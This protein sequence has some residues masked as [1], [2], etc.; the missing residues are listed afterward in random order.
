MGELTGEN[1]LNTISIHCLTETYRMSINP[2]GKNYPVN[3]TYGLNEDWH[4]AIEVTEKYD[5][6]RGLFLLVDTLLLHKKVSTLGSVL[7]VIST[8]VVNQLLGTWAL[9]NQAASQLYK[10][11]SVVQHNQHLFDVYIPLTDQEAA[12]RQ[13][14][15]ELQTHY[16][17]A[18]L[19]ERVPPGGNAER[20]WYESMR[21]WLLVHAMQRSAHGNCQDAFLRSAADHIRLAA[22]A[23]GDRLQIIQALRGPADEFDSLNNQILFKEGRIP[24]KKEL[25]PTAY[26]FL[27]TLVKVARG[28]HKSDQGQGSFTL[29]H[30]EL[31]SGKPAISPAPAAIKLPWSPVEDDL[32]TELDLV[33]GTEDEGNIATV[34]VDSN[35]SYE[36]QRLSGG[37]VLLQAVEEAQL[38]PWSWGRPN[39]LETLILDEEVRDLMTSS[40]PM[41]QLLGVLVWLALR[42][43]RSLRR[44]LSFQISPVIHAEWT[45]YLQS[46]ELRRSVPMR[47]HSWEPSCDEEKAWVT[48]VAGMN[49]I[50]MPQHIGDI[51]GRRTLASPAAKWIWELWDA[52]WPT[53]PERHFRALGKER[54]PRL[55]PGMLGGVLPQQ[56]YQVTNDE[57]LA[58][59]VSAH[60]QSGLSAACAYANWTASDSSLKAFQYES[61]EDWLENPPI[62]M[63]SRLDPINHHLVA[64]ISELTSKLKCDQAR[65]GVVECHNASTIYILMM[66][67][68]ATG[69]RPV[70]DPFES[71]LHFDFEEDF[72]YLDDKATETG[73]NARLVPLP[74]RL[75]NYIRQHYI[76]HLRSI[77]RLLQEANPSLA[78]EISSMAEERPSGRMPF[79]F[80]LDQE[81]GIR[82][83]SVTGSAVLN[84][85]LQDCPLPPNLFRQRLDKQLRRRG[86]NSEI[87]AGIFG[88]ADAGSESYGDF[89]TRVWAEDASDVRQALTDAFEALPFELLPIVIRGSV[90]GGAAKSDQF[91]TPV[92][93]GTAARERARRLFN[94]NAIRLAGKE[95][96]GFLG[97]RHLS[98]LGQDEVD[99][100]SRKMLFYSNGLPRRNGAIRYE[101]LMRRLEREYASNGKK[102]RVGKRYILQHPTSPFSHGAPLANAL[103]QRARRAVE[104]GLQSMPPSKLTITDCALLAPVLLALECLVADKE[105]LL[106]V[107]TGKHFR[108][109]ELMGSFYLE[110]GNEDEIKAADALVVRRKISAYCAHLLARLR[111][112]KREA[113]ID[114]ARV[115]D[116]LTPLAEVLSRGQSPGAIHHFVELISVLTGVV[117]Q[118]NAMNL[119]GVLAGYL[120]G[121]VKSASLS[122][123]NWVR[124]NY[125]VPVRLPGTLHEEARAVGDLDVLENPIMGPSSSAF[126]DVAGTA[127]EEARK[128]FSGLRDQLYKARNSGRDAATRSRP[129]LKVL[130][131]R[132]LKQARSK[133]ASAPL[134]LGF[135]VVHLLAMRN[136]NGYHYALSSI[137]RY[138]S[139]LSPYFV[140]VAS[141]AD[142][143][144]MDDGDVTELYGNI[145]MSAKPGNRGYV[146]DRLLQF[147]AFAKTL[148]VEDPDW[149]ELPLENPARH[150]SPGVI[151]NKEYHTA[152]QLLLRS[153]R[154]SE[155]SSDSLAMLLFLCYR[156]GLRGK[157]AMGLMRSDWL[158]HGELI[159][160]SVQNN[161]LRKLKTPGSRRQVPLV[162]NLLDAEEK[163]IARHFANLEGLFGKEDDCPIFTHERRPLSETDINRMRSL[164]IETLKA[165]TRDQRTNLHHARHTAAN[166][167]ALGALGLGG[168]I[169]KGREFSRRDD[170]GMIVLGTSGTTRRSTWATARYLGHV[171]RETQ[172]QNYLHFVSDWADTYLSP[173][174][175]PSAQSSQDMIIRL[176]DLPRLAGLEPGLLEKTPK[177]SIAP[178][179]GKLVA[180]LRHV[181]MGKPWEPASQLL[182]LD[183][184]SAEM[185]VD[186]VEAIAQRIRLA[187]HPGGP[188]MAFLQMIKK[189]GWNRIMARMEDLSRSSVSTKPSVAERLDV[190]GSEMAAMVGSSRQLIMWKEKHF[191]LVRQM[192]DYFAIPPTLYKVVVSNRAEPEIYSLADTAGFQLLSQIEAGA[193]TYFQLDSVRK[194][195]NTKHH[196][197]SRC[198]VSL[199][200]NSLGFVRTSYELVLLFVVFFAWNQSRSDSLKLGQ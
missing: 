130:I 195:P 55:T 65:L 163:L 75:S 54:L 150:A 155:Y 50:A 151:T 14:R 104:A 139:A 197:E 53:D 137:E 47:A 66:L 6:L 194:D 27:K 162:F 187:S 83:T 185:M 56:C 112:G 96:E 108:L 182:S 161:K 52:T 175:L 29:L 179:P 99:D 30:K 34:P 170:V 61:N 183:R 117:D 7:K 72:V 106:Q 103:L 200:K 95:I 1:T 93:F 113:K 8:P 101:H 51:I 48:P 45:I 38:L 142:L 128:L 145:L 28:D 5:C 78:A 42:T 24:D 127:Q 131:E 167:L 165:V 102:V 87:I 134:L 41:D 35:A 160:I 18:V 62:V 25:S 188:A 40:N 100:L 17:L 135:W 143:M 154:A 193:G 148:G 15:N 180:F 60:P 122:L 26:D 57:V 116:F 9:N 174:T 77:G 189:P 120:G 184:S 32:A 67:F 71:V 124:L 58:R 44:V 90:R 97:Q 59:L 74:V 36:L 159:V 144:A 85:G 43:G 146:G 16:M 88:H 22:A 172:F 164:V 153:G 13:L 39:P 70:R 119:P 21:A 69:A 81:N 196:V 111:A 123:R 3:P 2:S 176:D 173:L 86:V 129:R 109:V 166:R 23:M 107:S 4:L 12:S 63:G 10:L 89:S 76:S 20:V 191:R 92:L 82:W 91:D 37:A 171:R 138:L 168:K 178:T 198:V 73:R 80:L 158:D 181:A 84:I 79:F 147:H 110:L 126:V 121:R 125:G 118:H 192:L 68:A 33:N 186:V 19:L 132:E 98:Q 46:M 133:V 157:E 49:R 94:L 199:Q 152:L 11:S 190:P 114:K 31:E 177:P 105:A 149:D 156:F 141:K 115:P 136:S 140:G 64:S 169:W